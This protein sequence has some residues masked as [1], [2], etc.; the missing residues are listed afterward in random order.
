MNSN[1]SS[2][3]T[4][5]TF[6][7]LKLNNST[8]SSSSSSSSSDSSSSSVKRSNETSPNQLSKKQHELFFDFYEAN[9]NKTNNLLSVKLIK[10]L[11]LLRQTHLDIPLIDQ[12]LTKID[13]D[14]DMYMNLNEFVDLMLALFLKPNPITRT[15]Q[16]VLA[17][18]Y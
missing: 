18:Y 12:V 16:A 3:L 2:R 4:R 11:L 5:P 14:S 1:S 6:L 17:K 9:K 13:T 7:N 15:N 8:S 10:D